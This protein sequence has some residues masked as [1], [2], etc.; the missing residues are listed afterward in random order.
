MTG[1]TYIECL[2][3]D[4]SKRYSTPP[5]LHLVWVGVPAAMFLPPSTEMPPLNC[6]C[7]LLTLALGILEGCSRR[8]LGANAI[9]SYC[10]SKSDA[11]CMQIETAHSVKN[12]INICAMPFLSD[13]ITDS[14]CVSKHM[15]H[16]IR[17]IVCL[18]VQMSH[19]SNFKL[20]QIFKKINKKRQKIN[21]ICSCSQ[22]SA[23]ARLWL[24]WLWVSFITLSVQS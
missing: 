20:R 19:K 3:K 9:M 18:S 11:E 17:T 12:T 1:E 22:W 23:K 4:L 21:L 6:A 7:E 8:S 10:H 2:R 13:K 14:I 24:H 5:H 15:F 16:L